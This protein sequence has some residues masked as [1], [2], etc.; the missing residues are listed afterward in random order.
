MH[1]KL[2]WLDLHEEIY[3]P[4]QIKES[5]N[6]HLVDGKRCPQCNWLERAD[7][8]ECF[9]CGHNFEL[10]SIYEKFSRFKDFQLPRCTIEFAPL[11]KSIFTRRHIED[12]ALY[13][14]RL[15]AERLLLS[16]GFDELICI[17]EID[18]QHYSHQ[19]ETAKKAL[20]E[21]RARVLLADEVGLGKTIEAGI[22][23]KELLLRGLVNRILILT[24]ASLVL[25]WQEEMGY[26]FGEKFF[27]GTNKNDWPQMDRVIVSIDTAKQERFAREVH[28]IEYDLLIVDE[29]HKLKNRSTQV[30]RF[31]NRIRKKYVLMLTATPVHNDLGE[32]Y[33]LVTILKPGLLGTI[34]SFN[35]RFVQQSDRR[36]PVNKAHL[37]NLLQEV[38]IRNQ[39]QKVTVKLPPRRAAIYYMDLSPTELSFYRR[40]SE[41]VKDEFKKETQNRFHQLSLITLQKEL[42]SCSAAVAGTL[43]KM[44]RRADYPLVTQQK[45]TNLAVE[46]KNL[47][48]N[49]KTVAVLELLEAFP[50]KFLIYT[51]YRKTMFYLDEQLREHGHTTTLFHG[52]L[53]MKQKRAVIEEFAGP[54]RVLISTDAGSEGQNLQFCSKLI[55]Y[56]LPWN[57]MKIEQRI[58]RVHRLGQQEEVIIFNLSVNQTIEADVLELLAKK[59]R[60]FELVIGEM[61]LIL[62]Q[63]DTIKTFEATIIDLLL[64]N[65]AEDA[66]QKGFADF[67]EKLDLAREKF[68]KLKEAEAIVTDLM[69]Q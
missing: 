68:Q 7:A 4:P 50:G 55:N 17:N 32:L 69:S 29:A 46:A 54:A 53:N 42:C 58:G 52:G 25:Q 36:V 37:R 31:V 18:I 16:K 20:Q 38:M 15:S 56:D 61:D 64:Q 22:I 41:Y 1:E 67:G 21:M 39:R 30:Y 10:H 11:P 60:M 33:S 5:K 57:P 51:S 49:R 66:Q 45:I 6:P 47:S 43:E 65:R 12:N 40:V 24:P 34:R 59:I 35:K 63:L 19:I 3:R 27:I 9:R 62:G 44:A 2:E 23:M 13:D 28:R 14:L 8:V 26:K 48:V